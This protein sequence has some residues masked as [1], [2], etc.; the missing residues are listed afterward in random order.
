MDFF[1]RI[2]NRIKKRFSKPKH[3][4]E[5]EADI[6]F[7]Y[8]FL[9]K[10]NKRDAE[11]IIKYAYKKLTGLDH[12]QISTTDMIYNHIYPYVKSINDSDF[13][14]SL[15]IPVKNKDWETLHTEEMIIR[16]N[17]LIKLFSRKYLCKIVDEHDMLMYDV[18]YQLSFPEQTQL[19][20][21][22]MKDVTYNLDIV[23]HL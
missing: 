2:F 7:K 12:N 11:E 23:K 13:E 18:F 21:R 9:S 1:M 8:I 3:N 22:L 19:Y 6:L 5:N 4:I 17:M 10:I 20:F 14:K 15:D 16:I